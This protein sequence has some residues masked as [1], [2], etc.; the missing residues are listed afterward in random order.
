MGLVPGVLALNALLAATGYCALSASLA[1]LP[2]RAWAGYA[3][4]ALLVGAALAAVGTFL[5]AIAGADAGPATFVSVLVVVAAAG[6]A[7]GRWPRARASLAAPRPAARQADGERARLVALAAG[8]AIVAICALA[9]VGGFR[10]S[11]WLDDVWGIWLPKGVA[12]VELGLDPRLFAPDGRYVAF[13]V[14]D[15][16]LWW[17]ILLALD[18]R[19]VGEIDLRAVDAQLAI[20][21]V[22]FLGALARLLWG[23][24]RPWLLAGTLLLLAASPELLR[25]T[26]GGIADLPLALYL[27]L[28]ALGLAGWSAQRRAFWLL[29]ASV[30]GAAAVAIKS[31]G[32]P[33]LLVVAAVV[34]IVAAAVEKRAL[35]GIGLAAGV[36]VLTAVPWLVWRGVHDVPSSVSLGDALDPAY[37]ADRAERAGPTARSLATELLHPHWLLVVP[38]VLVLG[39][40]AARRLRRPVALAPA[41]LVAVLYAFWVWAYWAE[42]EDLDYL[43]ATSAYRVVDTAVLVAWLGVPLLAEA[44]LRQSSIA[45]HAISMSENGAT[46]GSTP[47]M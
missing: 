25:H 32:L 9:L 38:L 2:A 33:Q 35:A 4:L 29:V 42:T 5:A 10:S 44:V 7:V 46:A 14:L 36:A 23:Y 24:V 17:S 39:V 43:L 22:A 45:R 15:Y 34:A 28:F 30:A 11:P 13:E 40:V 8:F 18:L 6:L 3:G 19:F 47:G 27:A 21:F 1:T 20:L 31:E 41:A 37:L 12:L 16:P 26:Q